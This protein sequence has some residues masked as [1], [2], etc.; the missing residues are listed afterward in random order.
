MS[1]TFTTPTGTPDPDAA[2]LDRLRADEAELDRRE[3]IQL[4][5]DA[6]RSRADYVVTNDG[7]L[8]RVEAQVRTILD[9]IM[10]SHRA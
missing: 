1:D 5:L 8:S 3:E 10:D 6:K 9:T 2:L 7:D 4:R